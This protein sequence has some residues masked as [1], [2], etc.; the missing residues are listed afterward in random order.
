MACVSQ[1]RNLSLT[2]RRRLP[3]LEGHITSSRAASRS[4]L[5]TPTAGSS[6]EPLLD[7]RIPRA[8][9]H[10]Q[11]S[12]ETSREQE[13]KLSSRITPRPDR[14]SQAP[15]RWG[16]HRASGLGRYTTGCDWRSPAAA[17]VRRHGEPSA[18]VSVRSDLVFPT[19]G[20]LGP[21][22]YVLRSPFDHT[23]STKLVLQIVG[24]VAAVVDGV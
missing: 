12:V 17:H 1:R 9:I 6:A 19:L 23:H 21:E 5:E 11:C 15:G 10:H 8:I 24:K 18:I 20:Q 2:F 14:G 13:W 22:G 3:S 7:V 4:T 16:A